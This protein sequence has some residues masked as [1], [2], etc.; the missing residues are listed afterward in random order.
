MHAGTGARRARFWVALVALVAGSGAVGASPRVE[1][2]LLPERAALAVGDELR[3]GVELTNRSARKVTIIAE[4]RTCR[5]SCRYAG[6]R[7]GGATAAPSPERRA[8][9][10]A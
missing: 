7:E 2:R 4:P 6:R 1:M 9:R 3:F 5:E 10:P 8:G